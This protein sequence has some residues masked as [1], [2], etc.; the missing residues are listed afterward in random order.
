V[1]SSVLITGALGNIGSTVALACSKE[2]HVIALDSASDRVGVVSA[3]SSRSVDLVK[4][5]LRQF[6]VKSSWS[7]VSTVIHCAAT[8]NPQISGTQARSE[9]TQLTR[10][11]IKLANV[12]NA[13]LIFASTTSVYQRTESPR[14]FAQDV[15]G[16]TTEYSRGKLEDEGL[17]RS[18]S[19]RFTIVRL[20]SAYGPSLWINY[21][22]AINRVVSNSLATGEFRSWRF[23]YDAI[24]PHA[25]VAGIGQALAQVTASEDF[26]GETLNYA[27]LSVD[28]RS[29][30]E[31]L[32]RMNPNVKLILEDHVND[33]AK[34]LV[35]EPP[36]WTFGS[37]REPQIEANIQ[38]LVELGPG[39]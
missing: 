22:T 15:T 26:T 8:V 28:L 14:M 3:L 1:S 31:T 16:G 36:D 13:R 17:I 12:L 20:G 19:D 21:K 18:D 25:P 5:D 32:K 11:A 4:A 37:A 29:I 33:S 6:V 24:S 2:S 7:N 27:P 23:A 9:N 35:L 34:H 38:A 10:A 39:C 30:H